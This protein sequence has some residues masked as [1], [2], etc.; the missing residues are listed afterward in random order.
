M[1]E[2]QQRL[3]SG[4]RKILHEINILPEGERDVLARSYIGAVDATLAT[5]F[6][7]GRWFKEMI[8]FRKKLEAV[9]EHKK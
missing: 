1:R 9:A 3:S 6:D 8:V 4:Q 2:R 7:T 5:T